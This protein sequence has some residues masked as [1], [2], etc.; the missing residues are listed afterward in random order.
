MKTA[1]GADIPG[2][3]QI[4]MLPSL[5]PRQRQEIRRIYE[6][7]RQEVKPLA[8]ELRSLKDEVRGSSGEP[9]R[10]PTQDFTNNLRAAREDGSYAPG[11]AT[12]TVRKLSADPE[13]RER[14]HRL[15]E[16]LR[17]R[18]LA[19][20]EQVKSILSQQQLQ[21]FEEMRKGQLLMPG[22]NRP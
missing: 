5:S 2:W 19:S 15:Q 14:A 16:Q 18:R 7:A 9:L 11:E 12:A 1:L 4:R 3:E 22:V 10:Q 17:I 20:W 8:D 13:R 21:E 6:D